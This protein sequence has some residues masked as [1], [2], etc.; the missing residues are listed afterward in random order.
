MKSRLAAGV[1][2]TDSSA[3]GYADRE[4]SAIWFSDRPAVKGGTPSP[5]S[6]LG[7][8]ANAV[9][10][11]PTA[12]ATVQVSHD[13]DGHPLST[14][15][16]SATTRRSVMAVWKSCCAPGRCVSTASARRPRTASRAGQD[17]R[18]PPQVAERTG[19][20]EGRVQRRCATPAARRLEDMILYM[21]KLGAIVA[22]QGRAGAGDTGRQRL[23]APHRRDARPAFLREEPE[24][25]GWLHRL[26][27]DTSGVLVIARTVPAFAASLLA[28][29]LGAPRCVES[30]LGVDAQGRAEAEARHDQGCARQGRRTR[31]RAHGHRRS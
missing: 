10:T 9:N 25:A 11:G 13:E 15:G 3:A 22:E 27:R 30:L 14:A 24:A 4:S 21:D 26:D 23:H 12:A 6:T 17:V 16:S 19:R 18:V 28:Q 5:A 31:C 2:K 20:R 29:S 1:G 7:E 8:P